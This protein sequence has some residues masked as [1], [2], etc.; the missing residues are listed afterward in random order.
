MLNEINIHI[1]HKIVN[2]FLFISAKCFSIKRLQKKQKEVYNKLVND[3]KK[4]VNGMD[5]DNIRSTEPRGTI[6]R[7]VAIAMPQD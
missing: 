2:S 4:E 1:S 6:A 7:F 5:S 3:I